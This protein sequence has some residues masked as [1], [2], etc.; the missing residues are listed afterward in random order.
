MEYRL[1]RHAM[2]G[3][4]RLI[5]GDGYVSAPLG[6]GEYLTDDAE[7]R[8]DWWRLPRGE[9]DTALWDH[10]IWRVEAWYDADVE[11]SWAPESATYPDVVSALDY[12]EAVAPL[13]CAADRVRARTRLTRLAASLRLEATPVDRGGEWDGQARS[14][15]TALALVPTC[16]TRP[17]PVEAVQ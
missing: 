7:L 3:E 14:S 15:A 10:P 12:L 2:T 8:P 13:L 16:T 1:I 4:T 6:E 5:G 17:P 9:Y 11:G